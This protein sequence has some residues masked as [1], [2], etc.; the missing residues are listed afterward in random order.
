MKFITSLKVFVFLVLFVL[1]S[2]GVSAQYY[3]TGQDPASIKWKQINTSS[4]KIIFPESYSTRALEYANQLELSKNAVNSEY[5]SKLRKFKIVL[6]NQTTTSNAMVSPTPFH[7]D[8]FEMPDQST[9]A[10]VWS[11]QLSLHEYRHAVQMQKMRQGFTK[12]LY[13]AIGDQATAIVFGAFL[14]FWFI[15]G[16][17]VVSE[18]LYSNSGRGRSPD[19]SM[20]LKAQLIDKKTYSYDKALF[21]SFKNYTPDHY[22]LG[23]HMVLYGMNKHGSE[24]WNTSLNR[25]SKTPFM[26]V[27]FTSAIKKYHGKGKVGFYKDVMD[28]IKTNWLKTDNKEINYF[29]TQPYNK[30]FTNYRF[31]NITSNGN[32]IVLK[33]GIDDI[34]RFVM[35]NK[36]GNEETLFTPGYI[37]GNSLSANDSLIC[38]NEKS[39]H[40][41]WSLKDYSII[42]VHNYKS[43]KTEIITKKSRLFS[44]QLSHN[45]KF[46]SASEVSENGEY[47]LVIID[48]KSKKIVGKS[49]NTDDIFI[50]TPQWSS[51]DKSIIYI[52]LGNKG[53]A[54]F[55]YNF[56]NEEHLQLTEFT[57][58]D[59]KF[60]SKS[61]NKL[62]FSAP[63]GNTNNIYIKT[64]NNN[65]LYK[66]TDTRFNVSDLKF[67]PLKGEEDI[68]FA[69][70]TADGYRIS[71]VK[72]TID[73]SKEVNKSYQ[74]TS[75]SIDKLTSN[76]TFN[77]DEVNKEYV[78][79]E[80]KNYN[81]LTHLFNFHSWGPT[82]IDADNYSFAPG[83]NLL[84]QNLL[85]TSVAG[86]GYYYDTDEE[87][88]RLKF[89][90]DYYGW[91]PVI[92][93]SA[94]NAGRRQFKLNDS[95]QKYDEIK[96]NETNFSLGLYVPLNF[97]RSKWVWGIQPYI[98]TERKIL[99]IKD[100]INNFHE[101]NFTGLTYR[102]YLYNR[103]K[104]SKRDI[105]PRWGQS[106][107]IIYRHTLNSLNINE[108]FAAET[109]F[110]FPSFIKHHGLRFYSAY[111]ERNLNGYN[112]NSFVSSARGYSSLSF[113]KFLSFKADYAFPIIYPDLDIPSVAYLS[114]IYAQVF[115]DNMYNIDNQNNYSSAGVELYTQWNFLG[116]FAIFTI[117]T[118]YT[119]RLN[120]SDS[121]MELLFGISY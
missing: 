98:G 118:R 42:K 77:L 32:Y 89:T 83:V 19:F 54:I 116:H 9:Y 76:S 57:Y 87:S 33:N 20:D 13:F 15:E 86:I 11:K 25:V 40:L 51:D 82:V 56:E 109:Y 97:T 18:S 111:Q 36:E 22:T 53:K 120:Y 99:T 8:F 1:I 37:Y 16:D 119:Y 66:L 71:S 60:A 114:R 96:Y 44:P 72:A 74:K 100:T 7:G 24:M 81:K 64:V 117:G 17:A 39:Y 104:R 121:Q 47:S 62:L 46:I 108:Q 14:P 94:E 5:N 23:Y 61:G 102:V 105:F 52:G 73:S 59:I 34:D 113:S 21:G 90:Y 4:F 43:G 67:S 48:L 112:Y 110:Y 106:L 49:R 6:H 70:Y 29:V 91:W 2:S 63:Y 30:W 45:S 68:L 10:Q 107:D 95:T 88:G 65:K 84:S 27:P 79:Y 55:E 58:D 101:N 69:E 85:G 12:G 78:D 75:F 3:I 41:R 103:L 26:L 92:R 50:I 93:F 31:P 35:I 115:G 38:W 28:E 80:I